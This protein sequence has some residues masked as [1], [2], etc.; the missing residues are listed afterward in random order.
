MCVCVCA[1]ERERE[2]KLSENRI[3]EGERVYIGGE[4]EGLGHAL[5]FHNFRNFL[6]SPYPPLLHSEGSCFVVS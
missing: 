1:R 4:D 2:T 6:S 3:R 5:L